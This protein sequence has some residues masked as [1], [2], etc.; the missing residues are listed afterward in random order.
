MY[1][2]EQD[3]WISKHC[4]NIID[5]YIE[6]MTKSELRDIRGDKVLKDN[7]TELYGID[8]VN[9]LEKEGSKNG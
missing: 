5:Q 1:D 4:K 3:W 6:L 2:N 7:L 9:A 8:Y